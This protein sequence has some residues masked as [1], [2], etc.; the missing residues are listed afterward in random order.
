MAMRPEEFDLVV[1]DP[2]LTRRWTG[3]IPGVQHEDAQELLDPRF[4]FEPGDEAGISG[5]S[6]RSR[7][8]SRRGDQKAHTAALTDR[9]D[10]PVAPRPQSV[11]ASVAVGLVRSA[12]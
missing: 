6:A 2:I 4:R 3:C 11:S 10:R 5:R 8:I 9:V 12:R 7:A 1:D